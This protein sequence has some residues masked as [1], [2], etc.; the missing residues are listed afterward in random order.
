MNLKIINQAIEKARNINANVETLL[1]IAQ[2]NLKAEEDK[3]TAQESLKKDFN[4]YLNNIGVE[5]L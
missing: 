3:Q 5:V 2:E 1:K 4:S